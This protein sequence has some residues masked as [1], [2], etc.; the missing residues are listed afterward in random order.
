MELV[1]E[2]ILLEVDGKE[3]FFWGMAFGILSPVCLS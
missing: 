3:P 1:L 2:N